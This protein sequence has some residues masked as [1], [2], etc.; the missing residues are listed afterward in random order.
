MHCDFVPLYIFATDRI[1][2]C[3]RQPWLAALFVYSCCVLL[4]SGLFA[5][6]LVLCYIEVGM[7]QRVVNIGYIMGALL[8]NKP[9]ATGMV[10][11]ARW[12]LESN[13]NVWLPQVLHTEI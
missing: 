2:C 3:I 7:I 4:V 9:E 11:V 5:V 8:V 6:G 10:I 13:L 12:P 1:C